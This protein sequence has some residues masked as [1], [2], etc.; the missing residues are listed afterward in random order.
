MPVAPGVDPTPW[1]SVQSPELDFKATPAIEAL[2]KLTESA[3]PGSVWELAGYQESRMLSVAPSP[4]DDILPVINTA[5]AWL[6]GIDREG[7]SAAWRDAS[8]LLRS[9][10]TTEK[11]SAAMLGTRAPLGKA[12]VRRL[13]SATPLTQLP[14]GRYLLMQFDTKFDSAPAAVETVTF[15]HESNG[16]WRAAGYFINPALALSAPPA[17][18]TTTQTPGPSV[19]DSGPAARVNVIGAVNRPGSYPLPAESTLLDALAAAGGWTATA[20]LKK[21]SILPRSSDGSPVQPRNHDALAILKG[22]ASNPLLPSQASIS[23]P[24]RF[25]D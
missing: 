6:T 4:A 19:T 9:E 17:L 1:L 15:V 5:Q 10:I 20:N 14:G 12:H 16:I 22:E 21:V 23:I 18:Q 11:F 2:C 24:E 8:P 3:R 25:L 13:R 7:Y